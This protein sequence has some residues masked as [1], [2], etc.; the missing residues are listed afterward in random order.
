MTLS[1]K[2]AII[3][4]CALIILALSGVIG[5]YLTRSYRQ[6]PSASSYT[7]GEKIS[8]SNTSPNPN[9]QTS[10]SLSSES[11]NASVATDNKAS[12][13]GTTSLISPSGD[14]VSAHRVT[15]ST[16]LVSVCNSTPGASCSIRFTNSDG[17]TKQLLSQNTDSGGS[18]YWNNWTPRTIGLSPGVWKITAIVTLNG[19]NKSTQDALSLTVTP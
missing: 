2:Y 18:A 3:T 19:Q 4:F 8:K 5:V 16:S 13:T 15:L 9:A 11:N 1:K 14:F 10:K 17:V 12:G 7:K 6:P